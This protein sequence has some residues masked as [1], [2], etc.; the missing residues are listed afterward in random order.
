MSQEIDYAILLQA[1]QAAD[2]LGTQLMQ[3]L[4]GARQ[5]AMSCGCDTVHRGEAEVVGIEF[6]DIDGKYA[7][8]IGKWLSCTCLMREIGNP[9]GRDYDY[10]IGLSA[11]ISH[12][13]LYVLFRKAFGNIGVPIDRLFATAFESGVGFVGSG[14]TAIVT[15]GKPVYIRPVGDLNESLWQTAEVRI[16]SDLKQYKPGTYM[17]CVVDLE[18]HCGS[19]NPYNRHYAAVQEPCVFAAR[20]FDTNAFV[21]MVQ[22]VDVSADQSVITVEANVGVVFYQP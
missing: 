8:Q 21:P 3:R 15:A 7:N 22:V 18:S 5:G 16:D 19:L 14:Q 20:L 11:F 2:L 10:S 1:R 9:H 4:A 6:S 17:A 13:E 12:A